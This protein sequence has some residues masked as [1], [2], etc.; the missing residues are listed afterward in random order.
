MKI[1]LAILAIGLAIILLC[2]GVIF[3]K[4]HTFRS[5]HI[6]ENE[7]MKRD[8]I[9]CAIAEDKIARKSAAKKIKS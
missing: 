8:N 6:H 1:L 2:V 7:R 4:D 5:Q 3:R 9:H